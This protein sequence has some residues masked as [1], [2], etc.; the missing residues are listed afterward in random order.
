MVYFQSR[1]FLSRHSSGRTEVNKKKLR[2]GHLVTERRFE[3]GTFRI[4]VS[5]VTF[6]KQ[7]YALVV[8]TPPP[9]FRGSRFQFILRSYIISFSP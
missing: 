1:Y 5:R 4:Q 7:N 8:H 3:P 9:C 2:T 6:R